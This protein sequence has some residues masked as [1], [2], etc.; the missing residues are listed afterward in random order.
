MK[1][2]WGSECITPRTL[3]LGTRWRGVV[4]STTRPLY[5]QE[6]SPWYPLDR[7]MGGSQSRS[8]RGGEEK[9]SY[10]LPG[11]EPLIIQPVAQRYTTELSLLRISP[12]T[13]PYFEGHILSTPST[14]ELMFVFS[15]LS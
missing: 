7:R 9:N 14:D 11:L 12:R 3:D 10:P 8:G 5:S 6:K 13:R 2:Y 1:A 4:S 15:S